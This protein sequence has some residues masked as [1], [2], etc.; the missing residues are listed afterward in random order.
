[1]FA[2]CFEKCILRGDSLI[3]L[4]LL[5]YQDMESFLNI[6]R[7]AGGV[8]F[9]AGVFLMGTVICQMLGKEH[10]N[11]Q[12]MNHFLLKFRKSGL[13]TGTYEVDGMKVVVEDKDGEDAVLTKVS[14]VEELKPNRLLSAL[15]FHGILVGALLFV[16]GTIEWFDNKSL[17]LLL[18]LVC[19]A[20]PRIM[21]R[22]YVLMAKLSMVLFFLLKLL[23]TA[24]SV[25]YEYL[26]FLLLSGLKRAK[27]LFG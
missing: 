1:M 13:K 14:F 10:K 27:A 8:S 7:V 21:L 3:I 6:L 9:A 26:M 12:K 24:L 19:F 22:L 17:W 23:I 11:L 16:G 15:S 4:F 20:M 5:F 2:F 25:C 18:I